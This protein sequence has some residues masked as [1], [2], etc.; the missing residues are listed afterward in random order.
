MIAKMISLDWRSMKTYQIR[1]L[2]LPVFIFVSGFYMPLAIFPISIFIFLSFSINSFAVEEKGE[3]NHLYLTLPV[4]RKMIVTAR[5]LLSV[6]MMIIGL[7][8]CVFIM[9]LANM[10]S[11]SK[12]YIGAKGYFI[13]ISLCYLLY[14][15]LNLFMF[16]ILFK[17]GYQKGKFLGFYMPA[18]LFAIILT[19]Y[20]VLTFLPSKK[21]LTIDYIFWASENII[22][23]NILVIILA[24]LIL[25]A[26]YFISLKVYDKRDF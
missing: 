22:L 24:S 1:A 5:Y 19:L 8:L 21:T 20:T 12:W 2:L 25:L 10:I 15:I 4:S 13:I 7:I 26:S 18:T 3:L 14:S 17:M 23:V 16:P 9:P 6:I 11:P